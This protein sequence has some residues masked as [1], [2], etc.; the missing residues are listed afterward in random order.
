MSSL[1]QLLIKYTTNPSGVL[2][3]N[4]KAKLTL[5]YCHFYSRWLFLNNHG[6]YW[7]LVPLG[8][9]RETHPSWVTGKQNIGHRRVNMVEPGK[10]FK[11]MTWMV[12]N[13][14]LPCNQVF[15]WPRAHYVVGCERFS[16]PEW[17]R[18]G[19]RSPPWLISP[20]L[21]APLLPD[22]SN[23]RFRW[24]GPSFEKGDPG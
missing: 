14:V 23:F 19:Q 1:F 13:N 17:K 10:H 6:S 21:Q 5:E 20:H 15:L 16:W 24:E 8:A 4:F 2:I 3:C 9:R 22:P 11:E 12:Q 18:R 7:A